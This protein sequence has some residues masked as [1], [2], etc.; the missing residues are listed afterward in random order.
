[1]QDQPSQLSGDGDP[2]LERAIVL[3][4]LRHDGHKRWSRSRLEVELAGVK[5]LDLS[6]ALA[7]LVEYDVVCVRGESVSASRATE[8][9]DE[10][11]L[12]A[13]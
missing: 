1:M 7:R 8:R 9:L 13:I 4:V 2:R 12:I 5:P 10:L 11:E 3:Q 6:D